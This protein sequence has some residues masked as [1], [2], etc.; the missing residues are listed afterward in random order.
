MDLCWSTAG[1]DMG[2]GLWP[3]ADFTLDHG[4]VIEQPQ[5]PTKSMRRPPGFPK[6][7][8]GIHQVSGITLADAGGHYQR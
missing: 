7:N 4:G 1:E 2:G 5:F 6:G 3:K 8:Q